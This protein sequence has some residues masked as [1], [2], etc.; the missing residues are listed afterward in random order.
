M[1][2]RKE[3]KDAETDRGKGRYLYCINVKKSE[4]ETDGENLGEEIVEKKDKETEKY[5]K[6]GIQVKKSERETDG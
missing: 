5:T 2:K 4:R 3:Q 6:E 1:K